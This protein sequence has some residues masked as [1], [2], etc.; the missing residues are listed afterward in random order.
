[1]HGQ[2][3]VGKAKDKF[4]KLE[5]LGAA[6]I[7]VDFVLCALRTLRQRYTLGQKVLTYL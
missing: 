5:V 7:L 6:E 4:S 3:G 2:E 1:M